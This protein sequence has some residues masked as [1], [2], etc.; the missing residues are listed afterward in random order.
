MQQSQLLPKASPAPFTPGT[1]SN[2]KHKSRLDLDEEEKEMPTVFGQNKTGSVLDLMA[3]TD[4][5][6]GHPNHYPEQN[7][8]RGL[9]SG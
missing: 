1:G 4:W 3:G 9:D 8:Y 7:P 2:L 5:N 6:T